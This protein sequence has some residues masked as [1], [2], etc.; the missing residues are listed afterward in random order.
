MILYFIKIN[1]NNTI[2]LHQCEDVPLEMLKLKCPPTPPLY[3][4]VGT[5]WETS[6]LV[7]DSASSSTTFVRDI[8]NWKKVGDIPR[9]LEKHMA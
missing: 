7:Y 9:G 8:S 1:N 4:V 3:G 2:I 5:S 6:V